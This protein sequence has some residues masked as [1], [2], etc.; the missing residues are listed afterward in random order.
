MVHRDC[1]ATTTFISDSRTAGPQE[2]GVVTPSFNLWLQV[3]D[4]LTRPPLRPSRACNAA[5]G[6]EVAAAGNRLGRSQCHLSGCDIA[7]SGQSR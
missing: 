5:Q 7:E 4:I 6:L 3:P 1:E 2:R